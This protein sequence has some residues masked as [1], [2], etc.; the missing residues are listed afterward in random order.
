MKAKTTE[1]IVSSKIIRV[2]MSMAL[3][4]S[5]CV[6]SPMSAFAGESVNVTIGDDI[7]YAGYSTT[8]MYAEIGRAH[9]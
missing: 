3:A 1:R 4:L 2:V 6:S 5:V 9:V 8:H 7:P